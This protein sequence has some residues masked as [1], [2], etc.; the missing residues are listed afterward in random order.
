MVT[1]NAGV[2]HPKRPQMVLNNTVSSA[3]SL[4][5]DF[6]K[7]PIIVTPAALCCDYAGIKC[8]LACDSGLYDSQ[9]LDPKPQTSAEILNPLMLEH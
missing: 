4:Q 9:S 1:Q 7:T 2:C 3:I 5:R 8:E 6:G